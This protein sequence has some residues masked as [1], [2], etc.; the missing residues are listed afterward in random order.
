M[1]TDLS[2]ARNASWSALIYANLV[3]RAELR[4]ST[5]SRVT[6]LRLRS[7]GQMLPF[8]LPLNQSSASYLHRTEA[9]AI[10]A[11]EQLAADLISSPRF[12][13]NERSALQMAARGMK[14]RTV[15]TS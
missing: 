10:A 4:G 2:A 12:S 1:P 6:T 7:T 11:T 8:C 5:A 13:P 9:I 3:A 15:K 14:H